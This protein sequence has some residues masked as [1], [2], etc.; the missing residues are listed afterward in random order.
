Y[1]TDG[2]TPTATVAGT[3]DQTTY[4]APFSVTLTTTVKALGTKA[5]MLNSGVL[6]S[7]YTITGTPQLLAGFPV[8]A[9]STA[10]T[11][12]QNTT[13]ANLLVVGCGSY[14]SAACAINDSAGH[15]W[16]AAA[17]CGSGVP[18]EQFFY[19]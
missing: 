17:V 4:T 2:T 15:N 13:G 10:A 5:G 7:T 9:L 19:V 16:T 1:T 11:A 3:C 14:G 18:H 12:G 8:Q 6:S